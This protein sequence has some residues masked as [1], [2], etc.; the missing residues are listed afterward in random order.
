THAMLSAE[1]IGAPTEFAAVQL[2]SA[3]EDVRA[4]VGRFFGAPAK[5]ISLDQPLPEPPG[6]LLPAAWGQER[7]RLARGETIRLRL[8]I[9]GGIYA[10]VA[11][12]AVGYLFALDRKVKKVEAESRVAQ[13]QIEFVQTRKARWQALAPAIDPARYL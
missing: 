3:R 11:L 4:E 8:R 9:A 5:S 2:D 6:N 1:L 13:P 7:K 10:A 12:C